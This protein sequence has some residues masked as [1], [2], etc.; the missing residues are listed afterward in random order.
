M[1]KIHLLPLN[2]RSI[3]FN[4]AVAEL[5]IPFPIIEKDFWVVWTLERLFSIEELKNHLTFKGGTSLSKV[6]GIIERF[7]EDIDVSIEKDFLGFDTDEKDPE[8]AKTKNKQR[9]ALEEL[10]KACGKYV[11]NDM[12]ALLKRSISDEIGTSQG[13]QLVSDTKDPQALIGR[14]HWAHDLSIGP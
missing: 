2:E 3:Y 1:S 4:E 7:S 8:K 10:S 9:A 6:Y 5:D 12:A 14:L 13:W 11:Q